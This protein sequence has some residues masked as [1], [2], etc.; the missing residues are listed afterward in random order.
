ML[1]AA[2]AAN[3]A[4]TTAPPG[5]FSSSLESPDPQPAASTVEVDASGRPVQANLSGSSPTGL[6]G[7]LL[8]Q[9]NA[10]TA[11]AENPPNETAAN[12]KDG[13]PSTK[14]L[15]FDPTGWVTY[16]LA[17]PAA[18]VRYALTPANDASRDLRDFTGEQG[19]THGTCIYLAVGSLSVARLLTNIELPRS[20]PHLVI[21]LLN[22]LASRRHFA[23]PASTG[24]ERRIECEALTYPVLSGG[25]LDG[26]VSYKGSQKC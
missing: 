13:N 2:P 22:H 26:L 7:S 3:A 20:P 25:L 11:S 10:V 9:V 21:R 24:I 4:S 17:K 8:G 12:L 14:W 18:V 16:Q 19:R 1:V 15:A 23:S 5:N 6:P